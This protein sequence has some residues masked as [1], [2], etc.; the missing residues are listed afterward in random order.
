MP[1]FNDQERRAQANAHI[2]CTGNQSKLLEI[3][4]DSIQRSVVSFIND[5]ISQNQM[6]GNTVVTNGKRFS[7]AFTWVNGNAFSKLFLTLLLMI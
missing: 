2:W 3:T 1:G 6:T 7:S 4:T 5:A